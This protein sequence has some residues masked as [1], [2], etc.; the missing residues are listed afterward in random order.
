MRRA[1]LLLI[2]ATLMN[3]ASKSLQ[4]ETK[5]GTSIMAVDWLWG[6]PPWEGLMV[7]KSWFG[8]SYPGRALSIRNY[9]PYYVN[10]PIGGDP[11]N[12]L[13]ADRVYTWVPG[14]T[15]D[16]GGLNRVFGS[17]S[18]PLPINF[19]FCILGTAPLKDLTT[20]RF[21]ITYEFESP[22]PPPPE[23]PIPHVP[24][25]RTC[26]DT[27]PNRIE[28]TVGQPD[29]GRPQS[30]YHPIYFRPG[31]QIRVEAG[32]CVQT[33]GW[34]KTW[35]HYVFPQGPDSH[36]YYH[37][38][39]RIPGMI[40]PDNP[41]YGKLVRIAD[42]LNK[43]YTVP[44]DH[45]PSDPLSL[46]YEDG[47]YSD[48]SYDDRYYSWPFQGAVD[49][50]TNNQCRGEGEAWVKIYIERRPGLETNIDRPGYDYH[51]FNLAQ[52]SPD[53]CRDACNKDLMCRAF[54]YVHPGLQTAQAGCYLKWTVPK[55][56]A[57]GCCVSG[58]GVQLEHG[59]NRPGGDYRRIELMD[60]K[61]ELCQAECAKDSNCRSFTFVN[62][63]IQINRPVCY[64][65]STLPPPVTDS[66]CV[67][68]L[69]PLSPWA[70]AG[71]PSPIN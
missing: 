47:D 65:K 10:I 62:A 8:I 38:L 15:I 28:C 44:R 25:E 43:T 22:A 27:G 6:E 42:V 51:Y 29:V 11:A 53:Q 57:N 52:P 66:C 41:K 1:A 3:V 32:G 50:G 9:S 20:L 23:P 54:T 63:G 12:C 26:R 71:Q 60:G 69:R 35:K 13:R 48:N 36:Q 67:S 30:T 7:F 18:P 68:G 31:D 16:A 61:P 59:T 34:G 64:L 19:V 40:V 46:G 49:N 2:A 21:N 58:I 39:I 14:G 56:F 5:R 33:G 17:N 55:S 4:A 24:Y 45:N 37:G 70:A